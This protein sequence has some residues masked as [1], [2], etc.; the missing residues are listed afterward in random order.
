MRKKYSASVKFK[1]ALEALSGKPIVEIC[2]KYSVG[3]SM[4]HRWKDR[5]KNEGL[6]VFGEI[7]K[8]GEAEW[9]REQAKLYQRI[10][11]LSMELEYLKK[12]AG[13]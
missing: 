10:G 8:N 12:V 2:K 4:V 1:I 6:E 9:I 5:L 7:K 11:Q 3:Q 13:E